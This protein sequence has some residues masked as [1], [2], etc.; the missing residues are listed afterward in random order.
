MATSSFPRL[1]MDEFIYVVG[2]MNLLV[3]PQHQIDAPNVLLPKL[4][5]VTQN[6]KLG[7]ATQV[8]KN[9]NES[10]VS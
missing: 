8:E 7:F 2:D 3:K 6:L 1:N 9:K 4:K 10:R 5:E